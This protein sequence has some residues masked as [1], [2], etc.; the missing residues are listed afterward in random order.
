MKNTIIFRALV[1]L[2]SSL[3]T[4]QAAPEHPEPARLGKIYHVGGDIKAPRVIS[5]PQPAQDAA[6]E[7]IG[8][9]STHKK[10]VDAGTTVLSIVVTWM[11][12]PLTPSSSGSSSRR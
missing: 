5:S 4:A 11:R 12:R 1:I 3:L 2:V 8:E 6:N 9:K 10:T 7:K